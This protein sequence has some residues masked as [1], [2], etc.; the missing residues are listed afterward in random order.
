LL[1]QERVKAEKRR[2]AEEAERRRREAEEARRQAEE[3]RLR[4]IELQRQ[5]AATKLQA[6]LARIRPQ[7]RFQSI[8]K[9]VKTLQAHLQRRT[10][11]HAPEVL[12]AAR[13]EYHARRE[14]EVEWEEI[15]GFDAAITEDMLKRNLN[16]VEIQSPT[17]MTRIK[18]A[19]VVAE[20]REINR[21][22]VRI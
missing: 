20:L 9:H 2:I 11:C 10:S 3:A 12:N 4:A 17:V 13:R 16:R 22:E 14:K 8:R 5:Q 15:V 18:I 6:S 21:I 7:R 1:E 19:D